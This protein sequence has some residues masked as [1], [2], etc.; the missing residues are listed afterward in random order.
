[1]EGPAPFPGFA[2]YEGTSA[3][4]RWWPKAL[5]L[6]ALGV[7]LVQWSHWLQFAT[8]LV[9]CAWLHGRLLPWRFEVQPDGLALVFPFGKRLF[10]PKPETTVRMETVGAVALTATRRH[11]GYLLL[12]GVLFVPERRMRMQRAFDFYGYRTI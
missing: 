6:L 1:V 5:L 9:V 4:L 10:L 2:S 11:L 8:V 12:D 7:V 3:F